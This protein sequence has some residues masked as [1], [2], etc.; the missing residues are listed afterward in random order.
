[1]LLIARS[2]PGTLRNAVPWRWPRL[3]SHIDTR[4][5]NQMALCEIELYSE[6]LSAVASV[7]RMLS[8]AEIDR[9]LGLRLT[10]PDPSACVPV[11]SPRTAPCMA[12]SA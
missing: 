2:L 6:V 4:L 7:D 3:G 8:F 12:T 9:A 10:L 11:P 5:H 1:M